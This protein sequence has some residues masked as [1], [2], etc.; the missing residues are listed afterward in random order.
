[1][2]QSVFLS[3]GAPDELLHDT[4]LHRSWQRLPALL[5]RPRAIVVVSAHFAGTSIGISAAGQPA[6]IHDFGGFDPALRRIRYPAPGHPALAGELADALASHAIAARILPDRGLDH[7]AWIPLAAAY[8]QADIPVVSL[9]VCPGAGPA[10]H[11]AVGRALA[12]LQR[13][14]ILLLGSGGMTHN[15]AQ[16]DWENRAAPAAPWSRQ[17][18]EWM[19]LGLLAGDEDALLRYR[20]LAPHA[21]RNHPTDEHLMPLFVAMGYAGKGWRGR[22]LFQGDSHAALAVDSYL[23]DPAPAGDDQVRPR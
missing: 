14:G 22:R 5:A 11:L 13:E 10:R 16:L 12:T 17:F 1:M 8:P 15:L 3:H 21:A 18:A 6:T 7:G 9:G 20:E 4:P 23:L 19:H 2:N